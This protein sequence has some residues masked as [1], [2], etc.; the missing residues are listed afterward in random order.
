M[1]LPQP[2]LDAQCFTFGTVGELLRALGNDVSPDELREVERLASLGLPPVASQHVLAAIFGI[3]PG[4]I[5]SFRHRT[6][7]HYRSFTIPKGRSQR[8]I[9]A[10]RVAL[11]VIQSWLGTQLLRAYK[12]P[13][14]VFGFVPTRS[15]VAAA[16]QHC[17]AR[18]VLS[19]DIR[20][21][22]Q[23]TPQHLVARSLVALG[24][25]Q[26]GAELIASISCLRG[27]LAQGSPASPVL[28]NIAMRALDELL[29]KEAETAGARLTRYADDIVLSGITAYPQ[30]L[31][32]RVTALVARTPWQLAAD[33]THLA[34][35]P[36]RLKVHGLLVHGPRARLTKG[37]RNKLRAYEHLLEADRVRIDDV[38]RVKGHLSYASFV[39][40]VT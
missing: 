17:E 12:P 40:R 1:R 6:A 9:D 18:W 10:P 4:L 34:E 37:Y 33:K 26:K 2:L 32:D 31:L 3:N 20:D 23:S 13:S 39:D 22:F 19:L 38:A 24:F 15:H 36:Q 21:F 5:W 28:S 16:V 11:K 27:N 25:G 29:A 8:R 30:G 7:R 35:V 14:H